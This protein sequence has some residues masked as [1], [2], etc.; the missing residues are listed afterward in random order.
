MCFIVARFRF[1]YLEVGN[2]CLCLTRFPRNVDN[3][4]GWSPANGA[5]LVSFH[6]GHFSAEVFSE[7]QAYQTI[8]V[9]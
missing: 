3:A 7:E 8:S 1:L 5:P 9:I 2:E 4:V 6:R